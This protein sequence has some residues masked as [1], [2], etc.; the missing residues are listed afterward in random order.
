MKLTRLA[1]A[2][3]LVASSVMVGGILVI[4][5]ATPAAAACFG[6]PQQVSS[7]VAATEFNW[8]GCSN[9]VVEIRN[10]ILRDTNCDQREARVYFQS[11]YRSRNGGGWVTMDT[12][13]FAYVNGCGNWAGYGDFVLY[14]DTGISS[15]GYQLRVAVTLY[16]CNWL[17][18]ERYTTGINF[19]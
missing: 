11:Q 8:S 13:G 19:G 15:P 18:S 9:G 2:L 14:P 5:H 6:G 12:A 16:A 7:P 4:A 17:C 10:G 1:R 3:A